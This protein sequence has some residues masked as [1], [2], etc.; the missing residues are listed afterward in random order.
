M[1][2]IGF[3]ISEDT[4][5]NNFIDL[6]RTLGYKVAHF[7]PARTEKGWRTA[8]SGDG[9]GFVDCVI[10]KP[11][12]TIFAE[13]KSESGKLSEAQAA[14]ILLLQSGGGEVYVWKPSDWNEMV[15]ILQRKSKE[16]PNVK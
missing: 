14:W 15:R 4:F 2:P 10:A 5:Q 12:R 3:Q 7:R 13:L 9:A 11:G 8:V 16:E 6:A 1:K